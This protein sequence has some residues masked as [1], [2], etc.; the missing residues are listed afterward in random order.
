MTVKKPSDTNS[1]SDLLM[2]LKERAHYKH[3]IEH[4][5]EFE[6]EPSPFGIDLQFEK[7]LQAQYSNF[8]L[9][10]FS[11]A[12]T[13]PRR[14]CSLC[15]GTGIRTYFHLETLREEVLPQGCNCN[16][17]DFSVQ[18][19]QSSHIPAKYI[20]QA[21]QTWDTSHFSS[22]TNSALPLWN[23]H[24]NVCRNFV[25]A[26][27]RRMENE[28]KIS[29]CEFLQNPF[30]GPS[31]HKQELI[32]EKLSQKPF[33]V[34]HGP[35]GTGKTMLSCAVL[36]WFAQLIPYEIPTRNAPT[37]K[38]VEFT[39]LLQMLRDGYSSKA[40]ES[41]V[42]QPLRTARVLLIDELGKGRMELDWQK[43][44]L[45]DLVTHRY[46]NKLVTLFTTNFGMPQ[47]EHKNQSVAKLDTGKRFLTDTEHS[48]NTV[49]QLKETLP[50]RVGPRIFDRLCEMSVFLPFD[51]FPSYRKH[52]AKKELG[53][54][55][56]LI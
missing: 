31:S 9:P 8:H 50:E 36:V 16:T 32:W 55:F 39:Q 35:V 22:G 30:F 29:N 41:E 53:E 11:C 46:N 34:F 27:T 7:L 18:A 49:T 15:K 28:F 48:R 14:T 12:E 43:E 47:A 1:F 38:F 17:L 40:S 21:F 25:V 3:E 19:L 24:G 37:I 33:L 54:L 52:I 51:S 2:R 42:M 44:K 4:E 26:H 10:I 5:E 20:E 23:M 45:D 56:D 6:Y 13:N